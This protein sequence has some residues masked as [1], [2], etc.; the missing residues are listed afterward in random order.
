MSL[1][2]AAASDLFHARD[3]ATEKALSLIG[4]HVRKVVKARSAHRVTGVSKSEMYSVQEAT[5]ELACTG[6]TGVSSA[7]CRCRPT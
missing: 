4:R 1:S 6:C 2:T 5:C 7:T 3:A